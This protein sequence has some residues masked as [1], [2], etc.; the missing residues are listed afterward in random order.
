MDQQ[1]K[2]PEIAFYY[3]NPIW[4]N[5]DWIKNL[6]LFFDGIG[7]LVPEY[8]QERLESY[9]PAIVV[10]LRENNLLHVIEPEKALDKPSTEKLASILIDIILSGSLDLLA[11][12]S[13][14]FQHLSKSRL[15]R[16]GKLC[17][18]CSLNPLQHD[19]AVS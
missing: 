16:V 19:L 2:N 3:P 13:V 4:L 8:M 12:D 17:L 18:V 7:L 15:E 10:G 6:I 5:G 1:T 11:K 14:D 9:D